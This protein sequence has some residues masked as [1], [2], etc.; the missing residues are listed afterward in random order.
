MFIM[1]QKVDTLFLELQLG[2]LVYINSVTMVSLSINSPNV[3][4]FVFDIC[5]FYFCA[6]IYA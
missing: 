1:F 3:I 6:F 2:R 5:S 4:N